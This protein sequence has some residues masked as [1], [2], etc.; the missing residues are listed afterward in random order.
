M[1]GRLFESADQQRDRETRQ[2]YDDLM[3]RYRRTKRSFRTNA[4][5]NFSISHPGCSFLMNNLS[6]GFLVCDPAQRRMVRGRF[7]DAYVTQPEF[8]LDDA[9]SEKRVAALQNYQ[10][11]THAFGVDLSEFIPFH[12]TL[13]GK[14]SW[15]K[16]VGI[17]NQY[18]IQS[19]GYDSSSSSFEAVIYVVVKRNGTVIFSVNGFSSKPH[20]YFSY[21]LSSA[22]CRF[23]TSALAMTSTVIVEIA[24]VTNGGTIIYQYDELYDDFNK[25]NSLG[26]DEFNSMLGMAVEFLTALERMT[27]DANDILNLNDA[28]EREYYLA[29]LLN[30][31]GDKDP[32]L[33]ALG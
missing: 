12:K 4:V 33:L 19:N 10:K 16:G 32:A 5:A 6:D 20:L 30:R 2:A 29:E 14:D 31:V 23:K 28:S 9:P 21:Y 18:D 1:F 8:V 13:K 17:L 26:R 25:E 3:T 7:I 15:L 24:T 11:A 27:Y 22:L